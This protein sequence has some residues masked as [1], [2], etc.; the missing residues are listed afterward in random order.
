MSPCSRPL[1]A[2]AIGR[3]TAPAYRPRFAPLPQRCVPQPTQAA[4]CARAPLQCHRAAA[5][6]APV[7]LAGFPRLLT[8]LALRR[9]RS[10]ACRSPLR[11]RPARVPHSNATGAAAPLGAA[12]VAQLAH[13]LTA[14]A[15]RHCRSPGSRG[16]LR[17]C[18]RLLALVFC[19]AAAARLCCR[20][21]TVA[22]GLG[23]CASRSRRSPAHC[24][25]RRSSPVARRPS[26]VAAGL[27][28]CASERAP[29]AAAAAIC[30]VYV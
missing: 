13:L 2:G 10:A 25:C 24:R 7:P 27:R 8:A 11:P 3:R 20:L 22:A 26:P 15:S 12:G 16:R 4:P 5:H 29:P 21:L 19:A 30:P 1:G 18:R 23:P 6:L 14:L 17:R 28:A 9:C